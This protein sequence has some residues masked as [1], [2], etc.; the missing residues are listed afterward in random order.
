V[1]RVYGLEGGAYEAMMAEQGGKCAICRNRQLM[2]ALAVHHDH[3]TGAVVALLCS[4]CNHDLLGGA[5]DSPELLLRAWAV[6]V[7]GWPLAQ[8]VMAS[9]KPEDGL[10]ATWPQRLR[11]LAAEL[12]AM[13]VP[14]GRP[15]A[16][17][18]PPY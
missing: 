1:R 15:G 17:D 7:G 3:V 6:Q 18:P 16:G 8:E 13:P 11:W 9:S 5:W 2:R 10:P 14:V 12:E 4:S